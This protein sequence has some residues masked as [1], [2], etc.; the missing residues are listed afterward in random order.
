MERNLI[1]LPEDA[2]HISGSAREDGGVMQLVAVPQVD[3]LLR[4]GSRVRMLPT[5][6]SVALLQRR[7]NLTTRLP[8]ADH[9]ALTG[10]AVYS[11]RLQSHVVLY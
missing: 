10:N 2:I 9:T 7:V 3:T 8:N 1:R 5:G 6:M 4:H 11:R